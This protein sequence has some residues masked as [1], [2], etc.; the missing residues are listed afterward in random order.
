MHEDLRIFT[1]L[2]VGFLVIP[3]FP[4]GVNSYDMNSLVDDDNIK[5]HSL[6]SGGLGFCQGKKVSK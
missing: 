5:Y 3:H 4:M 1:W 2:R 6:Q